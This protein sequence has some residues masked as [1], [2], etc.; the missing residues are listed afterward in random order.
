V[1]LFLAVLHFL[2]AKN[3]RHVHFFQGETKK[4]ALNISIFYAWGP[5]TKLDTYISIFANSL[6]LF[7]VNF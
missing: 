4:C 7:L 2:G 5:M 6:K 3:A 1:T